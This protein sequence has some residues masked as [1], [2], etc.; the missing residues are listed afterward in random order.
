MKLSVQVMNIP[1]AG[2]FRAERTVS[3]KGCVRVSF[4]ET[5]QESGVAEA[6]RVRRGCGE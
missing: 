6:R 2:T 5:A 1:G 3:K 4:R